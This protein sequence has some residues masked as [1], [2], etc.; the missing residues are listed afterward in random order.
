MTQRPALIATDLDGTLLRSDGSLSD[1]SRRVLAAVEEAGVPV[2]LVTGRPLRWMESLWDVVGAHGLAIV[3][4]GAILYDVA[5]RAVRRVDGLA[6]QPGLALVERLRG[7]VPDAAF[8]VECLDG[9]RSEPGFLD[10][11]GVPEGSPVAPLVE[12]YR[13]ACVRAGGRKR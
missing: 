7:V 9:I 6:P 3:S 12:L 13:Q 4:N 1:A 10:P 8:A 2:V 11:H 5:S